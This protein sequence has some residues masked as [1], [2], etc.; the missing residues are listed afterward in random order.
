MKYIKENW[1]FFLIMVLI[2]IIGGYFSAEYTLG[3]YDQSLI[4][5]AIKE[6]G[7]EGAIIG[8][9]V[10]E[11]ALY[12]IIF[13][14]LGI[15][16]S[17]KV[18]LWKKFEYKKNALYDT[19]LIAIIGGFAII[20]GDKYVFGAFN[21]Q[22]YHLYDAKPTFNYIM[23]AF[24]YGGVFEEILMR[25]FV[26]SL[27]VWAISKIF[28]KKKEIP[29]KIH[30]I[31]NVVAGLLFAAGHIPATIQTFGGLNALLLIRCFVMNGAF[32]IAFGWLYRKYSIYYSM[33]AHFGCHLICI[34][35]WLLFV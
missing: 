35:I 24:T 20:L 27:I 9:T 11:V 26:M 16:L 29:T 2:C 23:S 22:V 6:F 21:N 5:E 34:I 14:A 19:L 8:V 28:Y 31:A 33:L 18:K 25:L 30:I 17:N 13:T 15:I 7:S 1:K 4:E 12:G 32:G 3:L 10:V